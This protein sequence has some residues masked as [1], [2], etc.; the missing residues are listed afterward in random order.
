MTKRP[1]WWEWELEL[2]SHVLKRIRDRAISEIDLRQMMEMGK[3]LRRDDDS[4]RCIVRPSTNPGA[5]RSSWNPIQLNV[6]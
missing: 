3:G 4:G 5:G 6:S 1:D 2:S